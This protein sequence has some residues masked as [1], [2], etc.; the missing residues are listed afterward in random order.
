MLT[1]GKP[2]ILR[3]TTDFKPI[4]VASHALLFVTAPT[5]ARSNVGFSNGPLVPAIGSRSIVLRAAFR[6]GPIKCSETLNVN[7]FVV[8][9][10]QIRPVSVMH[11]AKHEPIVYCSPEES[12]SSTSILRRSIACRTSSVPHVPKSAKSSSSIPSPEIWY[13]KVLLP[14]FLEIKEA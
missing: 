2:L 7:V 12:A 1:F 6:L 10:S 3:Q 11:V 9:G 14:S 13:W 8:P 5:V 4:S